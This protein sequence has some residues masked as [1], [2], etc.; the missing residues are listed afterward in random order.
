MSNIRRRLCMKY[1][2]HA[3]W[4]RK[5]RLFSS[6]PF[7]APTLHYDTDWGRETPMCILSHTKVSQAHT[8]W[9]ELKKNYSS[10]VAPWSICVW[11]MQYRLYEVHYSGLV[12]LGWYHERIMKAKWGTAHAG[13]L[14][15]LEL[16]HKAWWCP[17]RTWRASRYLSS[18]S[19]RAVRLV[20]CEIWWV[21]SDKFTLIFIDSCD[22]LKIEFKRWYDYKAWLIPSKH[23]Q[24]LGNIYFAPTNLVWEINLPTHRPPFTTFIAVD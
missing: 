24:A 16:N 23:Q 22:K 17:S 20:G 13:T 21:L 4:R 18:S 15:L 9:E 11:Y 5:N 19:P 8:D 6:L 3:I 1:F 14:V 12:F 2:L 7:K 10:Q